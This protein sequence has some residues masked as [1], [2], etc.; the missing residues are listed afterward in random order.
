MN[1][2]PT[3]TLAAPDIHWASISPVIVVL[4]GAVLAILVES[5][6]PTKTRRPIVIGV[7]LLTTLVAL[8]TLV[9]R[10]LVV[11]DAPVSVGEY[12]EDSLTVATQFLL[13]LVA[14]FAF[15]VMAERTSV[16]DGAFA[17][18]PSDRPGSHDEELSDRKNYQ[19]SEM[20]PLALFSLAGMMVFPAANS[21]VT[22]F[23]ALEVMSLP[24][25]VLAA[26]ARRR[27]QLS[28]EAALKYFILGAFASGFM[29]MG[30][31]FLYGFSGSLTISQV[32]TALPGTTGMDWLALAGVFMVCVGLLFKIGAAPFHAWTP[33][34]YTGA[35]TPVTG[36]MAAAVK[37]AAF[38]ALLRFYQVV[39]AL[40]QWDLLAVLLG[41]A[42]LT[43]CVG[44]F[45][46]LLQKDIKRMLAYSSIAHAGFVLLGVLSLTH[47]ASGHV[48]F[49]LAG[50]GFA[51]VGAFGII[52]LVRG[53]NEN[54]DATGEVT[55]I[56]RW[57]G[58]GR[59][60]PLIASA[61]LV[62]LLSFAGIPLTSGFIG[63]FLIFSDAFAAGMGW[64]VALALLCSA[65]TAFFYFRVVR[66]MFF[67]ESTGD[68]EVVQ[69]EGFSA[70]TVV[71][72][73]CATIILGVFPNVIL[74]LLD[75]VV[76]L[77]P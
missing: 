26:T 30:S 51:T 75:K 77:L 67:T 47:G 16:G 57:A 8:V 53:V 6:A 19:R 37:V 41:L 14:F 23:V 39:A 35:P 69:S 25:Y 62:F 54:G 60:N 65:V 11:L 20:F 29:L 21:F 73:A 12:V 22:L 5:F 66:L 31:A 15:M 27:R 49:Y 7:S 43:M 28:Q 74:S 17:A 46:G 76:I 13:V 40:L 4:A 64:F 9:A 72:C 36:F 55:D 70:V 2:L 3:E 56:T 68:V 18:Q 44:T 52:S 71:L 32:A 63:K 1:L 59:T 34:V 33:D 24:L 61:M 48:I 45:A 42:A 38:A 10:W 50:Y 58:I